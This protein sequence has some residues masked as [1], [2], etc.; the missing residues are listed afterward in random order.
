MWGALG[1]LTAA[2]MQT[3]E[4]GTL[5]GVNAVMQSLVAFVSPITIGL[6]YDILHAGTTFWVMAALSTIG[7]L[8]M[9]RVRPS[10]AVAKT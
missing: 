5:S 1:A 8:L 2:K 3:R 10:A 7:G 6:L 9:S 4:Q